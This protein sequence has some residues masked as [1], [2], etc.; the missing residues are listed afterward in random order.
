MG[1]AHAFHS[2]ALQT[3]AHGGA[4]TVGAL[5]TYLDLI[6]KLVRPL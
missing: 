6:Q 1:V 5:Q 4:P 2:I 3:I